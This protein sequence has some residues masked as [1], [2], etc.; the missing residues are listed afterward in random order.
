MS[1]EVVTSRNK[2]GREQAAAP[3]GAAITVR[4]KSALDWSTNKTPISQARARRRAQRVPEH[5]WGAPVCARECACT[6][7][8]PSVGEHTCV[9]MRE[10]RYDDNASYTLCKGC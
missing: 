9:Y 2:S 5:A 4:R 8:R 7:A 3:A 10:G 6:E 1:S